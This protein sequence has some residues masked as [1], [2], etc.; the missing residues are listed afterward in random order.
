MVGVHF[1]HPPTPAAEQFLSK[2]TP[3]IEAEA[4]SFTYDILPVG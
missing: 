2:A 4:V 1:V 3:L